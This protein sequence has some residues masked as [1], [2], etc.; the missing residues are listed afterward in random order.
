MSGKR[1]A[2]TAISCLTFLVGL[3][4]LLY[5]LCSN[6]WNERRHEQLISSYVEQITQ[7]RPEDAAGWLADADA[8]N[9]ALSSGREPDVFSVIAAQA[10]EVYLQKLAF[11]QDGIMGYLQIP[12][13]EV[14][15]P[16]YHTTSEEVLK[17]GVGHLIGTSLP[18]GGSST[19]SVLSTHRGLPSAALFTDLDLLEV[20][21]HFYIYILDRTLA[22]EVDLI[23]E[24]EPVETEM[25]AITKGQDY[26]TLLTCTPY[27]INTHRLLVRG[28][29]VEYT[30]EMA[31]GEE[32]APS[33]SSLHTRYGL[34]A[35]GGVAI[36][37]VFILVLRRIAARPAHHAR[38]HYK[39]RE[40][41]RAP[42][43]R[44][45]YKKRDKRNV[46]K[47][48]RAKRRAKEPPRKP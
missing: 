28:H 12:R 21:D 42:A 31:A 44:H 25:L 19:H 18:V 33:V 41:R 22:Y 26:V 46:F 32:A 38:H 15:L 37:I 10:K 6:F 9:E 4:L 3:S 5:P 8:Y 11:R 36:T 24:V 16:I 45:H 17:Q 35:G 48:T 7:S 14:S 39:R 43:R 27:G 29:R 34:W 40:R 20:G 23:S 30:E 1:R 2:L 47:M 13:I